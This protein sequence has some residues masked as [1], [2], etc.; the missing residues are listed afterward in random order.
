MFLGTSLLLL[1]GLGTGGVLSQYFTTE[2]TNIKAK[3]PEYYGEDSVEY[4]DP[5][6]SSSG[7]G[8]YLSKY[9]LKFKTPDFSEYIPFT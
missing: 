6:E 1:L 5:Y 4:K 7:D 3:F 8:N 9:I 2:K